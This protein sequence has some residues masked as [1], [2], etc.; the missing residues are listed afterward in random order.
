MLLARIAMANRSFPLRLSDVCEKVNYVINDETTLW[1]MRYGHFHLA[2][3][4]IMYAKGMAKGL[5]E[6][7]GNDHVCGT[8]KLR[9]IRRHRQTFPSKV[10]WRAKEESELVHTDVCGSVNNESLNQNK[11]FVLF[12][13][14]LTRMIYG[15]TSLAARVRCLL[16]LGTQDLS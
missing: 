10:V 4:R 7:S 16:Y 6:L 14:D 2:I 3:F 1:H 13:D 9:K 5:L 11:Y 8:C 15:C 12:I